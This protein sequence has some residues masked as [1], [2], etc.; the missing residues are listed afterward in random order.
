MGQRL[1]M[2]EV[3]M[4]GEL[5]SKQ[6][7]ILIVDDMP[8]NLQL[9]AEILSQEGYRVRPASSGERALASI[10]KE[11]PNLILLDI[12]MPGLDGFSVCRQLKADART[13][14]VPIIFLSALSETFDKVMAFQ[15]GGVD[16]VT[17]PF[18]IDEVIARV[19]THLR[20]ESMRCKLLEQNQQLQEHNA[21][22][23]R[24]ASTVAHDLKNPLATLAVALKLVQYDLAGNTPPNSTTQQ[25]LATGIK[26]V[27]KMA[28]IT[29]EL[30]LLAALRQSEIPQ[31]PLQ[32][33]VI[34]ANALQRLQ[35]LTDEQQP[36]IH[37][38]SQWPVA[39]GYAPWVEAVWT[40]YISNGIRH[41]CRPIRLELGANSPID[42]QV[43]FWVR[44]NGPGIPESV[45]ALLF[46]EFAKADW[47]QTGGNGLGL[48]IVR[49]IM[50]KLGGSYG[51]H[52]LPQQ[53]S[54]FFFTLQSAPHP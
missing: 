52:S 48:S 10:D 41:G 22:L 13:Q 39:I 12:M 46:S 30:L 32:M 28:E 40:N 7:S 51:F 47:P 4:N 1:R 38:P 25:S 36:T 20:L 42:G 5:A 34:V 24:F 14:N 18:Q 45:K 50:D 37:L 15:V 21:E 9:L 8:A 33:E 29:D 31:A 3:T 17:K 6:E 27:G 2:D 26:I 11:L 54:E 53:G 43:R 49:R 19:R 16:Y 23:D 35:A 44:D